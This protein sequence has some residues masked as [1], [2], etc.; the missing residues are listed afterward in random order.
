MVT[1][2]LI[3]PVGIDPEMTQARYPSIAGDFL[4]LREPQIRYTDAVGTKSSWSCSADSAWVYD[5]G[6]TVLTARLHVEST[7]GD[8]SGTLQLSATAIL[9]IRMELCAFRFRAR[10][11]EAPFLLDRHLRWRPLKRREVLNDFSPWVLRWKIEAGPTRELRTFRGFVSCCASWRRPWLDVTVI[12][13]AA[14]LHPRWRFGGSGTQSKAAPAWE[15]G[16]TAGVRLLL[17]WPEVAPSTPPAAPAR[18]PAGA[19]AAFTITDHCDFDTSDRL[20]V[21]LHGDGHNRGWLGRGLRLTK[22]VFAFT[23]SPPNRPPAASLEEQSYSTLIQALHDEGSEICPHG[24]N[25]SGNIDPDRFHQSLTSLAHTWRTRT[26]IDHG[27]TLDYCYTMGGADDPGYRLLNA[28]KKDGF[29]SLWAYHDVPCDPRISLNI[30][31][32]PAQFLASSA[33]SVIHHVIHRRPLVALHYVRTAIRVGIQGALG[34]ALGGTLSVLRS[35]AMKL[36]R[37]RRLRAADLTA[38]CAR[39]MQL[40]STAS[41]SK[42]EL[43]SRPYTRQ[44]LLDAAAVVYPER[45]A[46]MYDARDEDLLLFVTEEVLHVRDAYTR[47]ALDRLI[48]ERGLHIGHCYILNQLPYV[49][50]IFASERPPLRLSSKWVRFLDDLADLS[51]TGRL[52][53]PTLSE[54][55]EW[56]RAMHRVVVVPIDARS[57]RID[58]PLP[59]PVNDFTLLLPRSVGSATINWSAQPVKGRREWRD[60]L[61]VWGDLPSTSTTIVRWDRPIDPA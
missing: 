60:W 19:E 53:N 36:S 35:L 55:V 33:V 14:A 9:P 37:T 50:G 39:I 43:A 32:P 47:Q 2:P 40:L 10:A 5:D 51:R 29:T 18:F 4:H 7:N 1:R 49:H 58:N 41:T 34:D 12:L 48:S 20:E 15:P 42:S 56:V 57:V 52:W 23:T 61:A 8:R 3:R 59:Q 24:I 25:E 30:L 44:E 11:L 28:L 17:S 21:F 45:A 54:L 16:Q 38:S 6:K 26:W 13:D 31:A 22:G 27:T 46:P